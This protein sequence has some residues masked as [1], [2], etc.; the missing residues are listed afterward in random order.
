MGRMFNPPH[1]GGILKEDVLPELGLTVTQAAQQLGVSRV[2]LS[3]VVNGRS[4]ITPDLA[5]R[6]QQW[7]S[8][9]TATI[10]LQM[11][12]D[13]DLWQIEHSAKAP[14]VEKARAA[15]R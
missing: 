6:L 15:S 14:V 5:L 4:A 12:V 10:W 3:R 7:V 11:Q 13:Y 9:P 2:T 1:P 8:G